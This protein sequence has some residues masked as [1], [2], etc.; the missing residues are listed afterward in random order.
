MTLSND[1][2]GIP[3]EMMHVSAMHKKK[4]TYGFLENLEYRILFHPSSSF[5]FFCYLRSMFDSS[6]KALLASR[7][8]EVTFHV[9]F[10]PTA[11]FL[12]FSKFQRTLKPRD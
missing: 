5:V 6:H 12:G 8:P 4:Y 11:E 1:K 7:L 9:K 2:M 10:V 3:I